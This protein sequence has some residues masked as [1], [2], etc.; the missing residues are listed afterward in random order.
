MRVFGVSPRH[1]F[2]P[3]AFA[4]IKQERTRH[5]T[6]KGSSLAGLTRFDEP[7]PLITNQGT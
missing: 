1:P 6:N 7:P 2:P 4:D 3:R 5:E